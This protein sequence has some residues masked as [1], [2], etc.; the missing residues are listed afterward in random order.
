M[1]ASDHIEYILLKLCWLCDVAGG[2]DG[3]ISCHWMILLSYDVW[4]GMGGMVC[5]GG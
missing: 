3:V 2:G 5:T 4:V 1:S